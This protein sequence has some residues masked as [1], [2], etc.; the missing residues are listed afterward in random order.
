ML[1]N[2]FKR[3]VFLNMTYSMTKNVGLILDGANADYRNDLVWLSRYSLF[4]I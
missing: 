1:N 3:D 4:A 2:V